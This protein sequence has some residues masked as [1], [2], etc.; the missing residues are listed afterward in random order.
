MGAL[1]K[2]LKTK[3]CSI[4]CYEIDNDLKIYLNALEDNKLKVIYKDI[5]KSSIID[6]IQ[7]IT[8]HNLFIVGN[9]PYYITTPIIKYL[10]N[11]DLDI[12]E[13]VFMVQ[14]E[15]ANRFTAKPN[16]KDYGS[17]TLYLQY[18]FNVQKLF[19]VNRQSF[20]PVP[21]VES[22]IIRFSKRTNKLDV[23]KDKYFKLINDSFKMKRKTLKNNLSNYDF[24]LISR[25][26][27]KYGLD[28]NVRAE[29]LNE[30]IFVEIANNI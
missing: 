29:A 2:E 25:I 14:N 4:I 19:K 16:S 30:E 13:M 28:E 3:Q 17:I 26:L 22:A 5:L 8:Y 15:V 21:K 11:L 24:K 23:S 1:T 27:N 12:T 7:D 20:N 6:D 10:I 18:Y 9:L